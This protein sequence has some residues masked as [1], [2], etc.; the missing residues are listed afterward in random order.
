LKFNIG[1]VFK[2]ACTLSKE[3]NFKL[4]YILHP[5]PQAALGEVGVGRNQREWK[6]S[7]GMSSL[8]FLFQVLDGYVNPLLGCCH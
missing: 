8:Y 2:P 1:L 7:I 6:R 5:L 3:E 4:S